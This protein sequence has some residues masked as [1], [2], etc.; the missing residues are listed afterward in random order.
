MSD[1]ENE[2][3]QSDAVPSTSSQISK[4]SSDDIVRRDIV[5]NNLQLNQARTSNTFIRGTNIHHGDIHFHQAPQ[6][7]Q[8]VLSPRQ[9]DDMVRKEKEMY[10]KTESIAEMLRSAEPLSSKYLDI[11]AESFGER[12]EQVPILLNIHSLDIERMKVDHFNKGGSR[13]VRMIVKV[14]K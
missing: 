1:K 14:V 2:L 5:N 6:T 8:L 7:T 9:F 10:L 3:I 11:F 12:Y 4:R 13:E